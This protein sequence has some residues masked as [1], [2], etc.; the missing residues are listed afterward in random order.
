MSDTPQN[1][2]SESFQEWH[3]RRMDDQ[4][5]SKLEYDRI[6]LRNTLHALIYTIIMTETDSMRSDI[7]DSITFKEAKSAL[8]ATD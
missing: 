6:L 7:R 3:I 5:V 1:E 8:E 2:T 4:Y